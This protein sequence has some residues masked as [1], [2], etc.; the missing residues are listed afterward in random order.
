LNAKMDILLHILVYWTMWE[1]QNRRRSRASLFNRLE[2]RD[3]EVI[4]GKLWRQ[5]VRRDGEMPGRTTSNRSNGTASTLSSNQS[6]SRAGSRTPSTA[7]STTSP[8]PSR[9]REKSNLFKRIGRRL[10]RSLEM[11]GVRSRSSSAREAWSPGQ[12]RPGSAFGHLR[13]ELLRSNSRAI[14]S[15][16]DSRRSDRSEH[17]SPAANYVADSHSPGLVR[18]HSLLSMTTSSSRRRWPDS[19]TPGLARCASW[20]A[21]PTRSAKEGILR[22]WQMLQTS[23]DDSMWNMSVGAGDPQQSPREGGRTL[24]F[25]QL[26]AMAPGPGRRDLQQ[27]R[28]VIDMLVQRWTGLGNGLNRAAGGDNAMRGQLREDGEGGDRSAEKPNKFLF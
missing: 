20:S 22:E 10:E 1:H 7:S 5:Q 16:S 4:I 13:G 24:L 8:A 19:P 17:S 9:G 21:G 25:A 14:S 3:R 18:Q 11:I 28:I 2:P 26:H 12:D 15:R 27:D 6:S 23:P